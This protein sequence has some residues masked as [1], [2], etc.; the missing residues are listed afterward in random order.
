MSNY[1]TARA[2]RQA[3]YRQMSEIAQRNHVPTPSINEIKGPSAELLVLAGQEFSRRA[4]RR[5]DNFAARSSE[6]CFDM[7]AKL[8]RFGSYASERQAAYAEKLVV[9]SGARELCIDRAA[10]EG[11]CTPPK[12]PAELI[13]HVPAPKPEREKF[14][15]VCDTVNLN[16]FARFSVG[17]LTIVLKNDGS[18]LF[19]KWGSTVIGRIEPISGEFIPKNYVPIPKSEV[20]L[21]LAALREVEKDPLQAARENGI[22]TG[23]CSCCSRAL[24]DP[25]SVSYGIGPIC[26]ARGW[27]VA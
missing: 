7:A 26:R 20:E 3:S 19:V 10:E 6:V 12:A 14:P 11:P 2:A 22:R 4:S 18:L 8:R 15:Q 23:R 24:T 27:G 1:E 16:K 5:A 21:A 13:V 25:V 9:W 17:R